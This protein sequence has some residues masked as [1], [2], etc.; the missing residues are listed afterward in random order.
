MSCCSKLI[1][2]GCDYAN[3]SREME[4]RVVPSCPFCR[5]K[6]PVTKEEAD[7][8]R[9]KRVETNDPFAM[10]R[11]GTEQYCKG[12]CSSAF[13]YWTK[14]SELG[15]AEAHYKL[16]IMYGGGEGVEK[17]RSKEIYHLEEAAIGG[18]PDARRNLGS[19]EWM[20]NDD[21]ERAVKHWIIAATQGD[22][23]SIKRLIKEFKFGAIQKEVLASALR[24]HQAAV[25]AT[26]S[27]QREVAEK[28][29]RN[30]PE[31]R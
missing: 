23:H 24:A 6:L 21:T 8:Q 9:M 4:M 27:P 10:C 2:D 12:D 28:Y 14:A 20:N 22:D 15:F 17:N 13:E 16:S 11:E 7:K 19:D 30:A 1:C 18:H 3:A 29:Y 5:T 25:D 31:L 26:K